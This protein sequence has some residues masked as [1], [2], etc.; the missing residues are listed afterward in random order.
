MQQ[1]MIEENIEIGKRIEL[2]LEQSHHIQ[3]V[4]RMK[5][6]TQIRVVFPLEKQAAFG[7][8]MY[9]GKKVIVEIESIDTM[10]RELQCEITLCVGI[11]KKEKWEYLLQKVTELGVTTIVPFESLRTVVKNKEE[12][13]HKKYERWNKILLEAAEQSKRESIPTLLPIKKLKELNQF[14]SEL[15][16]VAF[17]DA[18]HDG[19][20][21]RDVLKNHSSITLVI[22]PEGGFAT[23]EID[24]LMDQGFLCLSLGKRI[25]RAETAAA[26]SVS[27]VSTLIE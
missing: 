5:P 13:I 2:S 19:N 11:L 17:E 15:N 23:E 16:C 20:K 9:Q 21:L 14:K 18:S 12:K 8:I 25:L 3:D 26:H 7:K 4:L 22:G 1:Y 6:M 27:A 24:Y 10:S